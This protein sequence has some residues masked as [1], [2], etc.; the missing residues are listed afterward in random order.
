VQPKTGYFDMP[1]S[2]EPMKNSKPLL[3]NEGGSLDPVE[4]TQEQ[5]ALMEAKRLKALEK[6]AARSRLLS[7]S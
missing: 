3:D 1:P 7:A 4:I 5:K 2:E 6:A